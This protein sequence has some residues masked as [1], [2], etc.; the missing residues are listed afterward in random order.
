MLLLQ[1][2]K[3]QDTSLIPWQVWGTLWMPWREEMRAA[4]EGFAVPLWYGAQ[5]QARDVGLSLAPSPQNWAWVSPHSPH[6]TALVAA[7]HQCLWTQHISRAATAASDLPWGLCITFCLW[8][9]ARAEISSAAGLGNLCTIGRKNK[10]NGLSG[11]HLPGYW[12]TNTRN[13]I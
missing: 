9:Q 3:A 2:R 10:S 11:R 1:G 6:S 13:K 8:L 7:Q 5:G 4:P 12:G